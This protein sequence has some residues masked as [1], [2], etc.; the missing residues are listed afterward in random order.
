MSKDGLRGSSQVNAFTHE[1]VDLSPEFQLKSRNFSSYTTDKGR[2][3]IEVTTT[4]STVIQMMSG[5]Q[6]RGLYRTLVSSS[7]MNC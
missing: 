5:L 7:Q 3:S 4:R 2:L 1:G 6:V